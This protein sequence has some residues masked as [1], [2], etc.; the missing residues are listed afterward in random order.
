MERANPIRSAACT[1]SSRVRILCFLRGCL[2]DIGGALNEGALP[3]EIARK[4]LCVPCLAPERE[5]SL[6]RPKL[7]GE[8][9]R[10][11]RHML[12]YPVRYPKR[13][14]DVD[15][16]RGGHS[17]AQSTFSAREAIG[18]IASK[19][20]PTLRREVTGPPRF[21]NQTLPD[22]VPIRPATWQS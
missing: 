11:P 1:L 3:L 13:K 19:C 18:P 14:H 16:V 21:K 6:W 4:T 22:F 15:N 8:G 7:K 5:L 10:V 12:R 20:T 17:F 2:A 9:G